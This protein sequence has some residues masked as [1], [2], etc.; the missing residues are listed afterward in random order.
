MHGEN[1][2]KIIS[3][4][5]YLSKEDRFDVHKIAASLAS[6]IKLPHRWLYELPKDQN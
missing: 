5:V 2:A 4:F 6:K 3:V 1:Y